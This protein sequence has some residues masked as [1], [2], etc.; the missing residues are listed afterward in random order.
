MAVKK[1]GLGKGL[2]SLIPDNKIEVK[3]SVPNAG[4]EQMM[5]INMV[6]P[7]REQPRRNFEE[8]SLLEL[9]DSIKQFGVLQPLIVRK[10]KDY[11]EI[12]AGERRWRAAKMAGVKE[13]PVII[14]DFTEQEVLEI[15]LIENIQREDLNPIE[16][17][18]AFKRLLTEF[19]LK[20]DE[21]AE[22][23][24]KSRTAVTNSMRLLKLAEK[25]QQ[26][27]ID[28][29]ITTGHARALLAIEDP[30]LQ[31][32]LAN[33]IFDEKLSVRETESLVKSIK[34][35]KEPK[36][37]KMVKNAFIYEDLE[38]KMKQVLGTKVN[39]LAKGNGK[40]RI[41]IE[42]YSDAELERMFEMIMSLQKGE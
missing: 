12:I 14:K 21:V 24:S 42:Y 20:Q 4:G 2:D 27:V 1:K 18:M 33:K 31:Y 29:M 7:N 17:A 25:V 15:A 13:I 40:G 9:A 28:D 32:N 8:D 38:D 22:R 6:E 36:Q 10:R 16:E 23:V 39:V 19:N 41:Q 3:T 37:K 26:M 35:P 5:K 11:Y 34:N 30:E